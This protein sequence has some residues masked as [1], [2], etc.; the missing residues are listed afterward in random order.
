MS[1]VCGRPQGREGGRLMWTN[2]ERGGREG[3]TSD[4]VYGR[5]K[6]MAPNITVIS[7]TTTTIAQHHF[8][9]VHALPCRPAFSTKPSVIQASE[10]LIYHFISLYPYQRDDNDAFVA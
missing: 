9:R 7:N 2:V 3:Q 5:H 10:I 8:H 4:F 6:W 1:T